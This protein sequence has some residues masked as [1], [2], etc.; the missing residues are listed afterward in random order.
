MLKLYGYVHNAPDV[1][2]KYRLHPGQVTHGGGE[3][4]AGKW[5][6]VRERII[7]EVVTA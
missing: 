5:V 1:L 4:G 2:V 6:L 3:G 7:Q